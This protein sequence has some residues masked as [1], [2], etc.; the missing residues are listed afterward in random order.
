MLVMG[1][2]GMIFLM[3]EV[4]TIVVVTFWYN[5]QPLEKTAPE[6]PVLSRILMVMSTDGWLMIK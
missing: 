4:G 6:S 3:G 1:E 2:V 5:N